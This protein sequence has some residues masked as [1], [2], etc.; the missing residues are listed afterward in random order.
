MKLDLAKELYFRELDRR[1]QLDSA[2][3]FNVVV[4]TLL[5]ALFSYYASA[6]ENRGLSSSL[7]FLGCLSGATVCSVGA[8]VY[9]LRSYVGFVWSYLPYPRTLLEHHQALKA[10][11]A[12]H[13]LDSG[14]P[15]DVFED[16]LRER[17]VSAATENAANNNARS[18]LQYAARRFIVVS[19]ILAIVAGLPLAKDVLVMSIDLLS[20]K[21]AQP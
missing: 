1:A 15:D 16:F 21:G 17:L 5:T 20:T 3:T 14:T 13:G 18:E 11:H 19:V 6:Y 2:P 4:L 7:I 12:E 10:Y 8:I 9:I